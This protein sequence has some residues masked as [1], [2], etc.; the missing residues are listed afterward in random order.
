MSRPGRHVGCA[1]APEGEYAVR[2]YLIAWDGA[3]VD[4]VRRRRQVHVAEEE[5]E[6]P[7]AGAEPAGERFPIVEAQLVHFVAVDQVVVGREDLCGSSIPP[8][9]RQEPFGNL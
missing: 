3:A 6:R 4:P 2:V 5:V 1:P 7:D 9:T 8:V